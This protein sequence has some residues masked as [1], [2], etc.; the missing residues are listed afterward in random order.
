MLLSL[1]W[2]ISGAPNP[3]NHSWLTYSIHSGSSKSFHSPQPATLLSL[4]INNAA[5]H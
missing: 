1:S 3:L 5:S 2:D 4:S